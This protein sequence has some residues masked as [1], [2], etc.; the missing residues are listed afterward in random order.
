MHRKRTAPSGGP[1]STANGDSQD[2]KR[3]GL[4]G[5]PRKRSKRAPEEY[6]SSPSAPTSSVPT[7]TPIPTRKQALSKFSLTNKF[8]PRKYRLHASVDARLQNAAQVGVA[9]PL[10]L[11][12]AVSQTRPIRAYSLAHHGANTITEP[13]I[14]PILS[15][16]PQSHNP[17][18][19]AAINTL[20]PTLLIAY[21]KTCHYL[22][23]KHARRSHDP[24]ADIMTLLT[25]ALMTVDLAAGDVFHGSNPDIKTAPLWRV[26][27]VIETA[28]AHLADVIHVVEDGVQSVASDR[29]VRLSGQ[30][31][32]NSAASLRADK[33]NCL[34][35][36]PKRAFGPQTKPK[37]IRM[38]S[39]GSPRSPFHRKGL[40]H[41]HLPEVTSL[42][43]GTFPRL[44]E[45]AWEILVAD[46]EF[47]E[48][49]YALSILYDDTSPIVSATLPVLAH[50]L[51]DPQAM[52]LEPVGDILDIV[53]LF[54]PRMTCPANFLALIVG[55][56]R[57]KPPA[58]IPGEHLQR[59]AMYQRVVKVHVARL[60]FM[61]LMYYWKA[62]GD[63]KL[64]EQITHFVTHDMAHDDLPPSTA[65]FV[66]GAAELLKHSTRRQ[67]SWF[68]QEIKTTETNAVSYGPT[69]F[70]S[71]LTFLNTVFLRNAQP[72]LHIEIRYFCNRG[73]AE[74]F[75][76]ELTLMESDF[77]RRFSPDQMTFPEE[78]AKIQENFDAWAKFSNALS[79]LVVKSVLSEQIAK[80][81]GDII[82]LFTSVAA[83]CK[84]MRN[85]SSALAVLLGL[86]SSC[87]TRLKD[88]EN[89]VS[90]AHKE[91][92][93]QLNR[94]FYES[95]NWATYRAELA[96]NLP[97]IPIAAVIRKDLVQNTEGKDLLM[98]AHPSNVPINYFR[99]LRKTVRDLEKCYGRYKLTRAAPV[100]AYLRYQLD[101]LHHV[102]YDDY[103]NGMLQKSLEFE[104]RTRVCS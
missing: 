52:F 48:T 56:F 3:P 32:M 76:R 62:S 70:E 40:P 97:A 11:A 2:I 60:L 5:N 63:K 82:C 91:L 87:V 27:Q 18:L 50:L 26:A 73:G 35:P 1:K 9:P 57:Q 90:R 20:L 61:W 75:A 93:K 19:P 65:R 54:L 64:L 92:Q 53:L 23:D 30:C 24:I 101:P 102:D 22:K 15:L 43:H 44:L 42:T 99:N 45:G 104:P 41:R 37:S 71:R 16:S 6:P 81:R 17:P 72:V 80:Y 46:E 67:S 34:S 59:W 95:K 83:H 79:L 103:M 69:K 8:S 58:T 29:L 14:P 38:R 4:F 12:A 51:T 89:H 33:T 98:K 21:N 36:P 28:V 77:F 7:P 86:Q 39:V 78:K 13:D 85:Y 55:R 49:A 96:Q 74:E 88:T 94:F 68:A 100:H 25:E 10:P 84:T 31:S 66:N 47:N